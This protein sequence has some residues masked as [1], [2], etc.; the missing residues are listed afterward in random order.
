MKVK[1]IRALTD[2]ELMGKLEDAHQELFNLRFQ[3]TTRQLANYRRIPQVRR[4][5]A[6]LM[7]VRRERQ[8]PAGRS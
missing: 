1:E 6:R 5:I 7:T 4:S 8:R 3:L 2:E